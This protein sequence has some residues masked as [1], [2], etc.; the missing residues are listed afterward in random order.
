MIVLLLWYYI[1]R[2]E[3]ILFSDFRFV[4]INA[5]I[6]LSFMSHKNWD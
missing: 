3:Y 6:C 1:N 4:H 2:K 5:R